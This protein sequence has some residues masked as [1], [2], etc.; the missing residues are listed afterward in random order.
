MP[1][2]DWKDAVFLLVVCGPIVAIVSQPQPPPPVHVGKVDDLSYSQRRN[3][4]I[5]WRPLVGRAR[6]AAQVMLMLVFSMI[7]WCAIW[8]GNR[9]WR[10]K[11]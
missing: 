2:F 9:I 7:A 4:A 8:L 5:P 3:P 11:T 10:V 6:D 1:R